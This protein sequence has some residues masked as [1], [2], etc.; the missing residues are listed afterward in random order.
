MMVNLM[1]SNQRWL[2]I[3]IS[4]L[5]LI[6]FL[7]Y[8]SASS[9]VERLG[10]DRAGTIYGKTVTVSEFQRADRQLNTAGELGLSHIYAPEF[11]QQGSLNDAL[12]DQYVMQ[13]QVEAFGIV[14][15]DEEADEAA[16]KLAAF[17]GPNGS[18]DPAV[19]DA[20]IADKLNPRG[21]TESQVVELVKRD[22][23]FAR[24]R[25]LVDSTVVVTAHGSADPVRAELRADGNERHP[26]QERGFPRGHG[27]VG[28]RH[29]E[30]L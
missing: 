30:N 3:V 14:A 18:F 13:H 2:M 8:F 4:V 6:S 25:Q 22:L 16:Q 11:T 17:R 27:P 20:F 29:Q 23:Q 28:G 9:R 19:K 15:S 24:L 7:Y 21:F 12:T 10:N 5:V 1:R 26:L